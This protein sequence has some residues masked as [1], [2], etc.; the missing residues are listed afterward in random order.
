MLK[1]NSCDIMKKNEM[2]ESKSKQIRVDGDL[3]VLLDDLK[4]DLG[5]KSYNQ[6]LGYLVRLYPVYV[7][8]RDII[9]LVVSLRDSGDWRDQIRLVSNDLYSKYGGD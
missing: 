9:S 7:A 4:Q 1:K 2:S 3:K 8:Q 5:L 6:L